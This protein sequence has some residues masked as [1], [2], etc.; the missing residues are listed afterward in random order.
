MQEGLLCECQST[1][2]CASVP[3]LARFPRERAPLAICRLDASIRMTD[4][5]V[6][7]KAVPTQAAIVQ[8]QDAHTLEQRRRSANRTTRDDR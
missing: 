8:R 5:E 4:A 3:I 6:R 7:Q 2:G 1:R